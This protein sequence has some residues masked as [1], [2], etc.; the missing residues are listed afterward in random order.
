MV[1]VWE[2]KIINFITWS[3]YIISLYVTIYHFL[4]FLDSKKNSPEKQKKLFFNNKE[5]D[6]KTTFPTVTVIVP[7]YNEE[8]TV[9]GTVKSIY[10]LKYPKKY[11]KV[12]CVNDGSKDNT[13][14][15]LKEIKKK[16]PIIIIN[17]KNQGKFKAMNNALEKINTDFFACLDA[18]SFI[19]PN[20]LKHM[21]PIFSDSEVAVVMPSMKVFKPKNTLE[22]LQ[23][24]EYMVNIFYKKILEKIESIHVAPGPF[25]LYRTDVVKKVGCF[26]KAHL[27][28]DLE[29]A[30][31]LQNNHYKLRQDLKSVVFTKVPSKLKVFYAQRLRWYLGTVKNVF[32]YK[33][34]AFNKSF[35]DF[36]MFFF[37][38]IG[39][40]GF[41]TLIG[42]FLALYLLLK[43][44]FRQIK[45]LFLVHFDLKTYLTTNFTIDLLNID[46]RVVFS[47][48]ALMFLVVSLIYFAFK[49]M[50]EKPLKHK[51]K[52]VIFF[53]IYFFGY[54]LLIG[55]SWL[56]VLIKLIRGK[57]V[58][59]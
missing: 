28:E 4:I 32:D 6:L 37:P 29:M 26:R 55:Y 38:L 14:S 58:S 50:K 41:L 15:K 17:Q 25:S 34:I 2:D 33:H 16:Y 56:L 19:E 44:V 43:N 12:V 22:V 35:G 52:S 51:R 36:G 39:M 5:Y 10:N 31:R 11:L 59:W 40:T 27:T 42:G 57:K 21:L 46:Y 8:K 30:L 18:D 48:L 20:A 24:L 7:A 47:T 49:A 3:L 1:F 23:W 9:E 54:S 13:L 45:N 53:I